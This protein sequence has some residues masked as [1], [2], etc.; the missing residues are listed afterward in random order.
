MS[1]QEKTRTAISEAALAVWAESGYSAL[2]MSAVADRSGLARATLYNH[3]RDRSELTALAVTA[4]WQQVREVATKSPDSYTLLVDLSDWIA[5]SPTVAGL[6]QESPEVLVTA[7][8]QVLQL[9]D[10]TSA[11]AIETLGRLGAHADLSAVEA[12]V[13]WLTSYALAPGERASRL[14]AAE[15]LANALALDATL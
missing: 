14:A 7:L 6:R 12:V 5:N 10:E 3:V 2:T 11:F 9:D 13:R 8:N 4:L 1:R 15:I